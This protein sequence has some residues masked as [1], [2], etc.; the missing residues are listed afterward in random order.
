MGSSSVTRYRTWAPLHWEPR[1]SATG[2]AGQCLPYPVLNLLPS[3]LFPS[4]LGQT[5][6]AQVTIGFSPARFSAFIPSA[7]VGLENLEI[8][9]EG[10]RLDFASRKEGDGRVP[11][12]L[13]ARGGHPLFSQQ[14][15]LRRVRLDLFHAPLAPT[16][17]RR[18]AFSF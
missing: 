4:P 11:R 1:V 8:F 7:L 10:M 14:A 12:C 13:D 17:N 3:A 18:A 16:S 2:P 15:R 5:P 6:L 9:E